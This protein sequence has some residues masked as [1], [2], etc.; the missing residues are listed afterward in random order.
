MTVS[1]TH[2]ENQFTGDGVQTTFNFTF[3]VLIFAVGIDVYLDNELQN[4]GF[5]IYPNE[6]QFT[7]P[8]GSIVFDVPPALGVQI[9]VRR[10][11]SQ[12][13]NVDFPLEAKLSTVSLETAFDKQMLIAQ[14]NSR[15]IGRK[16]FV[17]RG[18]WV[19]TT[20]YAIGEAV[21]HEGSSYLAIAANVGSE[22]PSADWEVFA[23]QGATGSIGAE[24]QAE[25]YVLTDG[26]PGL[27][28]SYQVP[29]ASVFQCRLYTESNNPFSI[30]IGPRSTLYVGPFEGEWVSLPDSNGENFVPL[31]LTQLAVP[32]P[33]VP[34]CPCDVFLYRDGSSIAVEVVRWEAIQ[35]TGDITNAT[36]ADPSVLT[37][38]NGLSVGNLIAVD[39]I[40]G[41]LGTTSKNGLNGKIHAVQA[42]TG[43]SI[44]LSSGTDTTGLTYTAGG[45]F[46]KIP[47]AREVPLTVKGGVYLKSTDLSR[48]YVGSFMTL[49]ASQVNKDYYRNLVWSYFNRRPIGMS[50]KETESATWTAAISGRPRNNGTGYGQTVGAGRIDLFVGVSDED[51][52]L[53]LN[54]WA[55]ISVAGPVCSMGYVRNTTNGFGL[56]T[57]IIPPGANQYGYSFQYSNYTPNVGY[58]FIQ[59][60]QG[61]GSSGTTTFYAG[62]GVFGPNMSLLARG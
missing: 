20:N 46:Y 32:I 54:A 60:Q 58:Q 9:D 6:D 15:E 61:P 45:N 18:Q 25:G 44:T 4:T 8:G 27:Q 1:T 48:L 41:S 52:P 59:A 3:Q 47:V 23:Q 21:F 19:S 62:G 51:F 11:T 7:S 38:I 31:R 17:W 40:V 12:D 35:T 37:A 55:T 24:A 42:A 43:T 5:A 34:Y 28:P 14:E 2:S 30:V 39:N 10:N 49:K 53:A 26:G 16:T 13:Q 22:P 56:A 50:A 57:A 29:R 36:A 33:A